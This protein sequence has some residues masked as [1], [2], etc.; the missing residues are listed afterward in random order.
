MPITR[1]TPA[2]EMRM[3]Y[4]GLAR[5]LHPD[6]LH[7]EGAKGAF[8]ML[9]TAY[10]ELSKPEPSAGAAGKGK[11]AAPTVGRSNENCVRTKV[12]CPRCGAHVQRNGGCNHMICSSC[13]THFCI[14]CGQRWQGHGARAPR[15]TSLSLS[16]RTKTSRMPLASP[17]AT[18]I[19]ASARTRRASAA[20]TGRRRG[21]AGAS[22]APPRTRA[23]P[24]R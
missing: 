20:R 23:T 17:Q 2:D 15:V 19:A 3:A 12:T 18:F 5:L 22:T 7:H 8:Q 10:E 16:A 1:D 9:A 13:S 21:S 6:K 14:V 4:R 24:T 11:A